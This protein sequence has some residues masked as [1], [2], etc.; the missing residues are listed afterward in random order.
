MQR[1]SGTLADSWKDGSVIDLHREGSSYKYNNNNTSSGGTARSGSGSG[2][3]VGGY[4]EHSSLS[5]VTDR[6]VGDGDISPS[7]C[8]YNRGD[9][10]RQH[11]SIQSK[12][13]THHNPARRISTPP[14]SPVRKTKKIKSKVKKKK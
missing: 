14:L 3:D 13:H 4:F 11:P 9:S 2:I 10:N 12:T 1:I 7:H 8:P 6:R 5:F